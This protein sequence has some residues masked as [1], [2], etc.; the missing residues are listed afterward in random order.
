MKRKQF[1]DLTRQQADYQEVNGKHVFTFDYLPDVLLVSEQ[2]Q[3][4][5]VIYFE[6]LRNG[7]FP[8][9]GYEVDVEYNED[10]IEL[11]LRVLE[12]EKR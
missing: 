2:N 9:A 12:E 10:A 11:F 1:I 5:G 7:E 4:K 6:A 3:D 8:A